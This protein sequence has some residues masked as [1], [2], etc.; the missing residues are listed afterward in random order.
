MQAT[1]ALGDVIREQR[2]A[3]KLSQ[4][5][6]GTLAGYGR[7]AAVSISRIEH[8]LTVPTS[9][10]LAGIAAALGTTPREIGEAAAKRA[11]TLSKAPSEGGKSSGGRETLAERSKKVGEEIE[12][13]EQLTEQ[14]AHEFDE[15]VDAAWDNF[16]TPL[17]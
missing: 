15:A 9:D 2:T 4:D 7:G 5:T 11:A 3:L 17:T 13:R 16:L 6:L 1:E 14:L 12:R 10:R 8:G